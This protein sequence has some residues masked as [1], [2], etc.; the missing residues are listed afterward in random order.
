MAGEEE[1]LIC[2]DEVH[3]TW[4]VNTHELSIVSSDE[5]DSV[6]GSKRVFRVTYFVYGIVPIANSRGQT[7]VSGTVEADVN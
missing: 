6:A 1:A 4:P 2:I 7:F 5:G 3:E